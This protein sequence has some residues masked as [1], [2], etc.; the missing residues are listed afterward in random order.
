MAWRSSYP[1]WQVMS[2]LPGQSLPAATSGSRPAVPGILIVDDTPANLELLAGILSHRAYEARPFLSGRLAL[3]A[4]RLDPPDLIL[5]DIHMPE[6]DG[7]DVC[8]QLKAD[9]R[10]RDIP[11]IFITARTE[12]ADKVEAFALGAVD[13]V[14][15]PFHADEVRA[16]VEAHLEIRRQ[17]RA[18]RES[19]EHLQ[20]L[21]R[22]RDSMVHMLVH[23]LRSPLMG[24]LASLSLAR[25]E[26]LPPAVAECIHLAMN[27]TET[28]IEM[29]S[30][31]LDVSKLEAAR[32]PLEISRADLGELADAAVRAIEPSRGQ[33]RLRLSVP[34]NLGRIGVDAGLI[35]RVMQNLLD[36]AL[37]FTSHASGVIEVTIA[38]TA[39]GGQ[40]VAIID[41]GPGIPEEFR[42]RIFDKFF[43]VQVRQRTGLRSTGLGLTFCKLA[44][45]AHGG[46]IGVDSTVGQGST[47]WFELP[48]R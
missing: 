35:R 9:D 24:I 40:R 13:Y 17:E 11:V 23:D 39:D 7:L 28:I 4:A 18:L 48:R 10:L 34:T 27:S 45:D 12:M 36:N 22:S 29:V 32:M 30:S 21:E 19:Y 26:A 20:E 38:A 6:M 43:Q 8:K 31:V 2:N 3:A 33:R 5:L 37:K 1:G 46:Q 25:E 42:P 16:R 44:I 14:T 47:F 41:N 15:K